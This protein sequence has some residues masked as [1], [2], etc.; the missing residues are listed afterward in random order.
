[1]NFYIDLKLVK[2]SSLKISFDQK[3]LNFL[4]IKKT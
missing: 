4:H 1:M 3:F 2:E